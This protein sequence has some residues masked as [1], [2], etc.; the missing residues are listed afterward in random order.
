MN[1]ERVILVNL[2]QKSLKDSKK[3]KKKKMGIISKNYPLKI[4]LYKFLKGQYSKF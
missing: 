3:K 2:F 1:D 4:L